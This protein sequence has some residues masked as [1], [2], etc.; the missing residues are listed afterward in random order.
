MACY[1]LYL[2]SLEGNYTAQIKKDRLEFYF[3]GIYMFNFISKGNNHEN[4][5]R[6]N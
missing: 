6:N 1:L 4:V 5:N 2:L 3:I